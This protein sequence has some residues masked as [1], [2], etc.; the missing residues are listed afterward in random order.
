MQII[1][2][3]RGHSATRVPMAMLK[4]SG[5]YLGKVSPSFDLIPAELM[6]RAVRL[7]GDWVKATGE[8][9]WDFSLL[10]HMPVPLQYKQLVSEYL[11]RFAGREPYAWKLPEAALALP[12]LVKLYPDAY[13]IHWVRDGRD[14][15][16][17]HHGTDKLRQWNIPTSVELGTSRLT[18][19]AISWKY[20]EDLIAATPKPEHWL[21]IRL[22]DMVHQQDE[23]IEQMSDFLGM[24]VSGIPMFGDVIGRYH[25]HSLNGE[26]AIMQEQLVAHGFME[27]E[28]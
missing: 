23:T 18:R 10:C 11:M 26:I 9:E 21:T 19:A 4:I 27:A 6:Y 22:C 28:V 2:I 17:K 25:G 20:H 5:V 1:I 16:L 13:Y 12:W 7:A 24:T 3:G 15:I 8:H 14:V